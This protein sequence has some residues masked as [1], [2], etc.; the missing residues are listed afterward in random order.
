[1]TRMSTES[2]TRPP[3]R[4]LSGRRW[5]ASGSALLALVLALALAAQG[6]EPE[7]AAPAPALAPT[8]EPTPSEEWI[9][10]EAVPGR[11]DALSS[12]LEEM[13]VSPATRK[14]LDEI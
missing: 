8:P 5:C 4:R 6:Q 11:A 14:K 10:P 9:R 2:A 1:M 13:K 12:Q 3:M 7:P